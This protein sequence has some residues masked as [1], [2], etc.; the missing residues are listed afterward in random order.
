[1]NLSDSPKQAIAVIIVTV[2]ALA[3]GDTLIKGTSATFTLWQ[4][5]VLRSFFVVAFLIMLIRWRVPAVRLIPQQ[6]T[7]TL[8]RSIC[9]TF[10]WVAYYFSLAHVDLSIAAATYYTLPLFI[11]L[12][13]AAFL[14]DTVR[15]I[16]WIA[17][18]LGF[19]GVLLIL[20][21]RTTNFNTYALLPLVSAILYAT[22]MIL[23]RSR[24]R[25]E[26]MF[27]L[28]LWLNLTML[29]LG[30]LA[31]VLLYTVGA[32]AEMKHA[33]PFLFGSW[34]S[35]DTAEI[36]ALAV[37]II[38]ILIGSTGAAY[39]YQKG[40]P[41]TIATFDFAYVA[42]ATMGGILMFGEHPTFRGLAGITLIVV[43]GILA[44][45]S[46]ASGAA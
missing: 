36:A 11:T 31:T 41:A 24:C 23:T 40:R 27:V 10:M 32:S 20:E 4:I 8:I 16:G 46:H 12:F 14:G 2:F 5:F 38:S 43:A 13:S 25:N 28:S 1:M 30:L 7:W 29:A 42:F 39:A 26:H 18:I 22:A 45:R 21:P 37:L 44:V 17:V 34:S 9:L 6:L 3:L 35:I 15:P 19:S 33:Q